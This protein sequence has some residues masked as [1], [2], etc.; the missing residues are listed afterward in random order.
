MR[1]ARVRILL[2]TPYNGDNLGDQAIQRTLIDSFKLRLPSAEIIG[3][4]LNPRATAAIHGISC[5]PLSAKIAPAT[6]VKV[7]Q[8]PEEPPLAAN[9]HA[10]VNETPHPASAPLDAA[11]RT[12][13][14]GATALSMRSRILAILRHIPFLLNVLRALRNAPREA[15]FTIRAARLVHRGDLLLVAGGGQI[16]DEWG[17]TWAHPFTLWRWTGIA[18]LKGNTV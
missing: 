2:L 15:V 11:K 4:T 10:V 8:W 18:Q 6:L 14:H 3:L 13:A 5:F 12:T 7:L 9:G 17:G 1:A 16:A